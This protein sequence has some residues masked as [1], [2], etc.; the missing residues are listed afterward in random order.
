MVGGPE[1]LQLDD[2]VLPAPTEKQVLVEV[3]D[4]GVN[5]IDTYHRT[6]LYKLPLPLTLGRE[7]AGIIRAVGSASSDLAVGDRVVF[8]SGGSYASHVLV[9]AASCVKLPAGLS[10]KD[11]AAA[12]LQGIT[13][14]S[15][16]T[17]VYPIKANDFVLIHAAAGGTG[18]LM[19]QI[20]KIKGAMSVRTPPNNT[21][22]SSTHANILD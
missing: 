17:S 21:H 10:L 7:A 1:S 22:R 16:I 8:I 11:A 6:G 15:F 18:N 19:V 4:A 2:V 14:H 20:A 13:A 3:Y 5:Y 12:H 9:D